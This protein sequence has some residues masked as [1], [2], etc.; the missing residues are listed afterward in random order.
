MKPII[1]YSI[2]FYAEKMWT[3]TE[4]KVVRDGLT[5]LWRNFSISEISDDK[6]FRF[7]SQE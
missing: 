5:D 3:L 1:C 6:F 2:E 7:A 4:T